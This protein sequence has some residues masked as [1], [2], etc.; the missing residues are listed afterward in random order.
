MSHYSYS[1]EPEALVK[2]ASSIAEDILHEVGDREFAM[3]YSG[4]SGVALATALAI[5]LDDKE[6]F[7]MVYVRKGG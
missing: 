6:Q 2:A 5:E 4:M 1:L 7:H 3:V